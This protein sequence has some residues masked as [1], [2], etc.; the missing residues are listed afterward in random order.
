MRALA[1]TSGQDD[2]RPAS[3][4]DGVELDVAEDVSEP[5]L[6]GKSHLRLM[7]VGVD[8]SAELLAG[9]AAGVSGYSSGPPDGTG[10]TLDEAAGRHSRA[11]HRDSDAPEVGALHST[12]KPSLNPDGPNGPSTIPSSLNHHES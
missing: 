4:G 8:P 3:S 11:R 5:L 6:E 2:G 12:L 1:R 7:G 9:G 10:V